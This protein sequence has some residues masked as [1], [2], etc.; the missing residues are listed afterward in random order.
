[1]HQ[2]TIDIPL[3]ESAASEARR[4]PLGWAELVARLA[5]RSDFRRLSGRSGA[6]GRASFDRL[7]AGGI[8]GGGQESLRGKPPVNPDALSDGKYPWPMS[9][10]AVGDKAQGDREIR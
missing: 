2:G 5:A 6:G 7:A 4:Q 1:M 10:G 9:S 8:T 3:D